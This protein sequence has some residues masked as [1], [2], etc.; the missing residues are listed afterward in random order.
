L[1]QPCHIFGLFVGMGKKAASSK[2]DTPVVSEAEL[3]SA[4][5]ALANA[6]TKK[7]I[8]SN[9]HYYLDSIGK[10]K[11]FDTMSASEKKDFFV[12][13]AASKMSTGTSSSTSVHEVTIVK[14]SG[15]MFEWMGKER[16]I[17]E[18]GDNKATAK[19]ASGLLES[20][21]DL[22][23]GVNDEWSTEYK[24]FFSKGS[25]IEK[26]ENKHGLNTVSELDEAGL[27]EAVDDMKSASSCVA[28]NIPL[29]AV[30]KEGSTG[31]GSSAGPGD[32]PHSSHL[33]TM[34]ALEKNPRAVLRSCGDTIVNIKQMFEATFGGKYTEAL[35]LDLTKILP[36]FKQHFTT[37]EKLVLKPRGDED[38]QHDKAVYLAIAKKLDADYEKFNEI[39]DWYSRLHGK[40]AKKAKK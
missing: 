23:T 9:M 11:A 20:R 29:V 17:K 18:L 1:S 13:W 30:K 33:K 14:E 10:K 26:D 4:K 15:T 37:I 21:A 6:V 31:G 36:K 16:M 34:E 39:N 35:N 3:Q 22:D 38:V 12:K 28:G 32:P 25:E 19:I 27:A 7:R 24:V 8:N 5:D 40:S 2:L